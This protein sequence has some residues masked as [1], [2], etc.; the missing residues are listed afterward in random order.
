MK[1]RLNRRQFLKTASWAGIG[2]WVGSHR[3]IAQTKSPNERLNIACIGV[4]NHGADNVRAVSSENIVALCDV[5][6]RMAWRAW[7]AFPGAKR[8]ADFR[9]GEHRR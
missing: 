9:L 3:A 2:C 5:D 6:E 4:G 1:A 7:E 8:H